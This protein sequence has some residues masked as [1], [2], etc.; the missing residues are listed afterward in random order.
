M[1]NITSEA[2]QAFINWDTFRKSNTTVALDSP[3]GEGRSVTM[4]LFG[5]AIAKTQNCEMKVSCGGYTSRTT[6]ERLNGL[7]EE[8]GKSYRVV[9][10][11][12]AWY[13][14]GINGDRQKVEFNTDGWNSLTELDKQFDLRAV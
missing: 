14:V 8:L 11:D 4:Y 12:W 13:F 3:I 10:S 5:N 9:Q 7:L 1:R 2:V 6:K